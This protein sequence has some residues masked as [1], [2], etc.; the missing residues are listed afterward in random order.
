MTERPNGTGKKI[1]LN[2]HKASQLILDPT[3][4]QDLVIYGAG[5]IAEEA[6]YDVSVTTGA[7]NDFEEALKLA[8]KMIIYYGMGTNVIYPSLSE[9]YKELID[10][11]VIKLINEAY[12]CSEIIIVNSKDLIY[13]T[14]ELLKKDKLLK[15]DMLNELIETKYKH[16]KNIKIEFE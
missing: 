3:I 6:F 9:K 13:E 12:R 2:T 10:I 14:S 1:Y 4:I 15:A 11:E 5:R 7:I 16:L 8:E